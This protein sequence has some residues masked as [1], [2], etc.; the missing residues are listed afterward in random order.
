LLRLGHAHH[1]GVQGRRTCASQLPW[2]AM[3]V[4][5]PGDPR[6]SFGPTRCACRQRLD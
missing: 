2:R 3:V 1:C 5:H 6:R 4:F